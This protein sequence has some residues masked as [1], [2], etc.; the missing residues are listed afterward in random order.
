MP[1]YL[2]SYAK[3]LLDS[4]QPTILLARGHLNTII[5]TNFE[6]LISISNI[7]QATHDFFVFTDQVIICIYFRT[8]DRLHPVSKLLKCNLVQT[9][10]A[11]LN[12]LLR[13]FAAGKAPLVYFIKSSILFTLIVNIKLKLWWGINFN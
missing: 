4:E 6:N 5:L 1:V 10:N 11:F 3:C 7:F 2:V 13:I 9:L 12:P 8:T